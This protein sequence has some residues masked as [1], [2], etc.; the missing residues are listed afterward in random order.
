MKFRFFSS[1]WQE[2][3]QHLQNNMIQYLNFKKSHLDPLFPVTVK[4]STGSVWIFLPSGFGFVLSHITAPVLKTSI[5]W[6]H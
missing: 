4:N 3:Y 5:I 1:F 6:R 2:G